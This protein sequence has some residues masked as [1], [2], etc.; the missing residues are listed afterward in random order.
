MEKKIPNENKYVTTKEFNK[1]TKKKFAETLKQAKLAT[2]NDLN[3]MEKIRKTA[4]I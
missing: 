2:G 3:S 4:K 1:L